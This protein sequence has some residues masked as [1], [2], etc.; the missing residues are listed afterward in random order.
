MSA[1]DFM[2]YVEK[3]QQNPEKYQKIHEEFWKED[4]EINEFEKIHKKV[5]LEPDEENQNF[6]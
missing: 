3:I 1:Y 4:D 5:K 2:K 6:I